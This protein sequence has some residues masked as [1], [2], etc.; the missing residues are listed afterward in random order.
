MS[1]VHIEV[2]HDNIR[3][4]MAVQ[5]ASLTSDNA[6]LK[7]QVRVLANDKLNLEMQISELK[8]ERSEANAAKE[9]TQPE[10]EVIDV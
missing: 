9:P 7:E 4:E 3:N 1:Q 10:T 5:I 2:N 8:S 6:V